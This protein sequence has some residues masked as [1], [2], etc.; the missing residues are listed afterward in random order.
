MNVGGRSH[1]PAMAS[2]YISTFANDIETPCFDLHLVAP[3]AC[4]HKLPLPVG[5][6]KIPLLKKCAI[7]ISKWYYYY[8]YLMILISLLLNHLNIVF[9]G[10]GRW[11]SIKSEVVCGKVDLE[12]VV[13][14]SSKLEGTVL[15]VKGE[16]GDVNLASR[17]EDSWGRI[18]I[19]YLREE[20]KT[21]FLTNLEEPAWFHHRGWQWFLWG[22]WHQ[23]SHWRWNVFLNNCK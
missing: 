12:A 7:I 13:G 10:V 1:G 23:S 4:F 3:T 9:R 16:P 6:R 19:E 21:E 22:R 14:P 5:L 11:L 8:W 2:I 18:T 17:L 15:L 20:K